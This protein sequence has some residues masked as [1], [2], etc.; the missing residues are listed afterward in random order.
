MNTWQSLRE[1][2]LYRSA[3]ASNKRPGFIKKNENLT[4]NITGWLKKDT[5]FNIQLR[6]VN[7]FDL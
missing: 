3:M 1:Q 2:Q 5:Y 7:I 6:K 4:G